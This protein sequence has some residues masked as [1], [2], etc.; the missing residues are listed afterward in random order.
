MGGCCGEATDRKKGA[1]DE[2]SGGRHRDKEVLMSP[3]LLHMKAAGVSAMGKDG[4]R[5]AP[6]TSHHPQRLSSTLLV[7]VYT[8]GG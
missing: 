5:L 8:Q 3:N 6:P 1:D 4:Q 2:R 7:P